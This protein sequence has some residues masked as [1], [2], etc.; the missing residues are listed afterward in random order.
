MSTVAR[1]RL[2]DADCAL[3]LD[4]L[5]TGPAGPTPRLWRAQRAY[6]AAAAALG[7][8]VAHHGCAAPADAEGEDV[9]A[10]VRAAATDPR[11]LSSQPSL[12]LRL[13]GLA[14]H[15]ATVMF[16]VH[17]DTVAG[18]EDV[19][20]DGARFTGR[21][22]VDAKGPA[23]ALLA[24]IRAALGVR[25]GLPERVS[26]LVQ[27]VAG[28]EGGVL[29]TIGT[30]RLVRRGWHGRLN[31]FCEPTGLRYL[32][33]ATAAMTARV[34]VAGRDAVDDRPERGHNASVLLGFLAQYFADELAPRVS[35]ACCIS[36][37]H[38]GT[39]HNRVYGSGELLLNLSYADAAEGR[40]LESAVEGALR[41]G[42]RAFHAR[43]A[44]NPVLALTAADAAGITRLHWDKRGL[45]ALPGGDRWLDALLGERLGMP[46]WPAD[47]PAFTC[48]AIWLAGVPDTST[49]VLGPGSLD[50]NR[51]HAEGEYAD[52]GE[53]DAFAEQIARLLLG[54]AA[55]PARRARVPSTHTR[56]HHGSGHTE[57]TSLR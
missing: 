39:S 54:F 20:F 26:V 28:E 55:E 31:V 51:A 32:T 24:G 34:R 16:N 29:G 45:P 3:L 41:D 48:D 9:P 27:V 36:G 18:L 10:T 50:T 43:F 52:I 33:R 49:V 21:G 30:R 47:E 35:G 2:T 12:V 23:V 7:F 17:L 38:T 11:F 56:D 15:R 8:V 14:D 5:R 40:V 25:P 42:L 53:L 46:A 44:D 37:L 57:A 22:A 19:G 1:A 13:G 4:L 6:A